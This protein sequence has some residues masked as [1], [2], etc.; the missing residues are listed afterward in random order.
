MT[1]MT[2]PLLMRP[3]DVADVAVAIAVASQLLMKLTTLLI[4]IC[5]AGPNKSVLE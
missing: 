1:L 4:F 3:Q 2:R 5:K